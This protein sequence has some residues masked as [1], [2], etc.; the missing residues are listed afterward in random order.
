MAFACPLLLNPLEDALLSANAEDSFHGLALA[1]T[2]H[3]LTW[4]R[5]AELANQDT[6]RGVI[7]ETAKE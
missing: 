7:G 6:F 2:I 3:T 1:V 5:S 4:G